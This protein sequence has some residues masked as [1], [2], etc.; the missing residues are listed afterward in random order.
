MLAQRRGLITGPKVLSYHFKLKHR[1]LQCRKCK[2]FFCTP[3][4]A[5]TQNVIDDTKSDSDS[6]ATIILD[7]SETGCK[8][9]PKLPVVKR[10]TMGRNRQQLRKKTKCTT[11]VTR[12]YSLRRGGTKPKPKAKL[13]KLMM[14]KC[15][16]C[17][18]RWK[19]CKER[20]DHLKLKCRK[21][22]CR[23][24]KKFFRTPS[25]FLLHQYVHA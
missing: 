10:K 16:M 3:R 8:I 21:L 17:E 1:K 22:Q 18:L 11:F 15:L 9:T 14:F 5:P 2:K 6:D 12:T 7:P 4:A 25:A 13:K 24:C 19:S 20:N 23:K